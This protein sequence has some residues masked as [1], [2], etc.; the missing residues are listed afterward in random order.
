VNP[1]ASKNPQAAA[2]SPEE[3]IRQHGVKLM[4][5]L[6]ATLRVG[7]AYQVQNQVFVTQI[8]Q[9]LETLTPILQQAGEAVLVAHDSDL[10]VN[11]VRV[12]VA[13]ASFKFQQTVVE[14]FGRLGISGIRFDASVT[15]RELTKLFGL[16]VKPDG[17]TGAALLEATRAQAC[18]GVAPILFASVD[19]E[20]ANAG[21]GDRASGDGGGPP[22]AAAAPQAPAERTEAA[23]RRRASQAVQG[24]RM[25]LM[26]TSLQSSLEVRHAKRVVQP[27]V[28]GVSLSEPVVVGL[29]SLHQRDEYTYAHAVNVCA[30]SVAIGHFLGLDR[31]ALS[32]LG[33]AALLHD[34]GKEA[35]GS[36]I[37]HDFEMMTSDEHRAAE[38]H[39]IEGLKLLARSTSLNPTTLNCMRVALEHHVTGPEEYPEL[40]KSWRPSVLSRIVA[41]A[42]CFINLQ[43][44][45][46][47]GTPVSPTEA[48]GMIL[49]PYAEGFEP[50]ILWALVRTVGFYPAGQ[51]VELDDGAL[52]RVLAPNVEDP[53][54]PHVR[55]MTTPEKVLLAEEEQTE[56]RPLAGDRVVRRAILYSDYPAWATEGPAATDAAA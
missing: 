40:P 31:R 30:V 44:R 4:M 32:D 14:M 24:A 50:A 36:L 55:V 26:P 13:K 49:G 38:R 53:A 6:S 43:S 45:L 16:I 9:L 56:L 41:V 10:Y 25:L 28:E 34:V 54:R 51:I 15:A 18:T 35:V 8:A 52:G 12:P 27:L 22:T 19:P 47:K 39:T 20:A 3:R 17:P 23:G 21:G 1:G 33:V 11:G 48:L 2:Q 42:D 37:H 5:A 29:S 46:G 7:K